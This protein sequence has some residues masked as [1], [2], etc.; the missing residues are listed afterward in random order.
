MNILLFIIKKGKTAQVK[1]KICCVY[2]EDV[3][4]R[5]TRANWFRRFQDGNFDVND[6]LRSNRSM[7][8]DEIFQKIEENRHVMITSSYDN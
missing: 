3:L 6:V 5:Q 4:I 8:V 7:C 1:E 2:R